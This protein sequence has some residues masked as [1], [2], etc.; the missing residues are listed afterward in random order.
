MMDLPEGESGKVTDHLPPITII[1]SCTFVDCSEPEYVLH[2]VRILSMDRFS[3]VKF[4]NSGK[5]KEKRRRKSR[6]WYLAQ[7]LLKIKS[8]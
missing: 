3:S 1:L 7:Y 6:V 4:L 5:K 8:S 2:F